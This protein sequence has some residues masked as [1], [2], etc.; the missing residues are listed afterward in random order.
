VAVSWGS[1]FFG[2]T[3]DTHEAGIA[4]PDRDL[5]LPK[6]MPSRYISSNRRDHPD[7]CSTC[8][9]RSVFLWRR[10]AGYVLIW[11]S[12]LLPFLPLTLLPL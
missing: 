5:A 6:G 11:G 1:R 9:R 3:V 12:L 2:F 10:D 7:P 4:T 8:H